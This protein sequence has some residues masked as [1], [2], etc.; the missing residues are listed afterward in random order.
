MVKDLG[1]SLQ[2]ELAV[3]VAYQDESLTSQEAVEKMVEAGKPLKK[4][5]QQK[6]LFAAC[7]ILQS[8]LLKLTS[9]G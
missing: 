1:R 3:K 8:F 9:E 6:D 4:R 2:Q 5:R 7:L